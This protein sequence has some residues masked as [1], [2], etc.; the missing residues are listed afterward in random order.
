MPGFGIGIAPKRRVAQAVAVAVTT[1][2]PLDKNPDATLSNGNRTLTG[3]QGANV[4]QLAR[5]TAARLDGRRNLEYGIDANSAGWCVG[6]ANAAASPAGGRIFGNGNA[7]GFGIGIGIVQNIRD[8]HDNARQDSRFLSGSY[9]PAQGAVAGDAISFAV[10][11]DARR[12]HLGRSGVYF[13]GMNP[14]A[15]TGGIPPAATGALFPAA[16]CR[17]GPTRSQ[18][19]LIAGRRRSRPRRPPVFPHG[20]EDETV[21]THARRALLGRVPRAGQYQAGRPHL[22]AARA[23]EGGSIDP[24]QL[25]PE[26]VD[27]RQFRPA[28]QIGRGRVSAVLRV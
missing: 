13:G 21:G 16:A 26:A 11:L 8:I 6:S 18:I 23:G 22:D 19:T 7:N 3:L 12:I 25:R 5:G 28:G 20:D 15:R 24:V 9:A 14:G 1:F 2:D 27:L 17:R 10:D 4:F